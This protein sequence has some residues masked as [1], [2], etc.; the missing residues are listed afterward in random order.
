[1][2][3]C[4]ATGDLTPAELRAFAGRDAARDVDVVSPARGVARGVSPKGALIVD[5]E[6]GRE[7][8]RRGSLVRV[9][10]A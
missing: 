3:A 1:V 10:E 8:F 5:T 9:Q 6:S 7:L 4:R 2:E